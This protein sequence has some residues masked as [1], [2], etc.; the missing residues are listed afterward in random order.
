LNLDQLANATPELIEWN[1]AEKITFFAW[2]LHSH[3]SQERFSATDIRSCYQ[4]LHLEQP[5]RIGPFL[6]SMESRKPKAA[7]R[8]IRG[9]Y[10]TAPV[11]NEYQRKFG[12]TVVDSTPK[13]ERVLPQ[14]V[15]TNTRSYIESVVQQANGSYEHHWFDACS[16]MIR[17]FVEILIIEVYETH[18]R[19]ADI[20]DKNG[21]FLM[22]RDLITIT[23]ADSA[24]NLSRETKRVLPEVKSLGDRSAHNRRYIAKQADV[25]KVIPGLRVLADDLLHL[26]NLK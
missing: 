5:S 23:M 11:R 24:W 9:Y 10:L 7:I 4:E 12:S 25:D 15:V 18:K 2:F 26:A 19:T 21:D 22:L 17:K 1:H 6:A 8:D 20:K 14:S 16:V 13:S 3:R